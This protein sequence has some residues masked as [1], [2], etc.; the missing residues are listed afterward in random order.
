YSLGLVIFELF[1]GGA[2]FDSV[3]QAIEKSCLF[4]TKLSE[5][6][7]QLPAAFDDWLQTLCHKEALQ[8]PSPEDALA[9]FNALWQPK[10]AV[11]TIE[12]NKP[13][14]QSVKS[15]NPHEPSVNYKRLPNGYQLTNKYV[16]Q[17][18]LGKPGGFGIV[19]KVTD[20]F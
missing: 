6:Y 14:Q 8:R 3:T 13:E 12:A 2:A 15:L 18:P 7:K 19:Y 11:E 5:R 4:S 10:A 1:S 9:Q 20:T 16:V 17:Q